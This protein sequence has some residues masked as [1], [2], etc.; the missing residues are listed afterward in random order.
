MVLVGAILAC[1]DRVLRGAWRWTYVVLA[2]FVV[3]AIVATKRLRGESESTSGRS[4]Q[5]SS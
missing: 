4:K 3:L 2:L 1:Y 5:R